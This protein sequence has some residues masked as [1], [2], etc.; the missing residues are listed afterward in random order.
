MHAFNLNSINVSAEFNATRRRRCLSY[1]NSLDLESGTRRRVG[2][3]CKD[4]TRTCGI[5]ACVGGGGGGGGERLSSSASSF[6]SRSQSYALLKQQMEVAAKTEVWYLLHCFCNFVIF[7]MFRNISTF[8]ILLYFL[9]RR[10]RL[11]R[12]CAA[13]DDGHWFLD[14]FV[15]LISGLRRSGKNS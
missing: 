9:R 15:V 2:R 8:L 3:G 7:N 1:N 12:V 5:V 4:L 13:Q 6:L 10:A 14:E 11:F